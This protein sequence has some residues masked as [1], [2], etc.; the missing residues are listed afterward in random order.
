MD[1]RWVKIHGKVSSEKPVMIQ[2][3]PG[4]GLIGNIV[5]HHMIEELNME[6]V[7]TIHSN[8]FPPIAI[9]FRGTVSLPVR[10][11]ESKEHSLVTIISDIPVFPDG[12]YPLASAIVEWCSNIGVREVV[13]V[14]GVAT[15]GEECKVYGA[16]TDEETLKKIS[17]YV[18]TFEV[19]SIAGISGGIV[20]ECYLKNIPAV[21]LLGETRG[22][23][24]SP[25][26][27]ANVVEVINKVYNLSIDTTRLHEQ[28]EQIEMEMQRLAEQMRAE[29]QKTKRE[30]PIYG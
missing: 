28:A 10:I 5:V 1:E 8:V 9:L 25:G 22:M 3:F 29:A 23:N 2:G 27:A 7:G 14:A 18:E 17:P 21:A 24:P 11:Y 20:L 30:F 26:S 15:V 4:V 13:S 16:A 19:G 12:V 6:L